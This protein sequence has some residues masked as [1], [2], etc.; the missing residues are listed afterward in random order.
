LREYPRATYLIQLHG[1]KY[2]LVWPDTQAE[3]KL[4]WPMAGW[5]K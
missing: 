4:E 1:K 2:A 3:A 5:K